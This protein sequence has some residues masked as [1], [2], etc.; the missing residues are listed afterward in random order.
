MP[1]AR[2]PVRKNQLAIN[3]IA[4]GGQFVKVIH[5]PVP[6]GLE[7]DP[8]PCAAM[9]HDGEFKLGADLKRRPLE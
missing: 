5:E 8:S 3:Q 2:A 1:L 4:L 9:G 6:D 7:R